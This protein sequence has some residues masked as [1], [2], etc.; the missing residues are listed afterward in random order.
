MVPV[1]RT[2]DE[3]S[4]LNTRH[5]TQARRYAAILGEA[6]RRSSFSGDGN[7]P[8]RLLSVARNVEAD[9]VSLL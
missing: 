2:S 7:P 8:A 9:G 5:E 3:T 4:N 1:R 6:E